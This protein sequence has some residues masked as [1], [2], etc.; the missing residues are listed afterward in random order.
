MGDVAM[1]VPVIRCVVQQNP[2]VQ[3]TVLSR[4]FFKPFFNEIP[5]VSFIEVDVKGRHKGFL[6]LFKLSKELRLL[7]FDAVADLHNV[8]RSNILKLFFKIYFTK[9]VQIDKGR[10]DKKALTSGNISAFKQLK[11][12]HERYAD[13]F[14]KLGLHADLS[15]HEFPTKMELNPTIQDLAGHDGK[16]WIGIAPFAQ[17]ESKSYPLEQL[18]QVIASLSETRKY[19]LLLFGGG[20]KEADLLNNI[21]SKYGNAVNVVGKLSFQE[22]LQLI[23]NLDLMLSMD[24]GN[25]HLAAMY[26]VPTITLWGVTHPFAGFAPFGQ[27]RGNTLLADRA[28]YPLIPTSIYGNKFPTGYEKAIASIKPSDVVNK[29][30]SLLN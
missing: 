23:S 8:L 4:A 20:K 1:T 10:S 7:R 18:M 14:R 30:V 2:E 21:A 22:E 29:I 24:S 12:T 6:G 15:K 26:G 11:T 28:Q 5:N 19:K 3:I 17:Y 27:D 16:Q 9:V 13:V 25:G